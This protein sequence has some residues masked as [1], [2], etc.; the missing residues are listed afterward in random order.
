MFKRI[1]LDNQDQ[2][3][4]QIFIDYN[5]E[6]IILSVYGRRRLCRVILSIDDAG[7]IADKIN[8]AIDEYEVQS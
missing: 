8:D 2:T 5:Q 7:Y 4:R 6:G 1:I 3:A